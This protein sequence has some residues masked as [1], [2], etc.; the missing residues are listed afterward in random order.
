MFRLAKPLENR[1]IT[2]AQ[3]CEQNIR[4][5]A[6]RHDNAQA[7]RSAINRFTLA[8]ESD[9]GL[10]DKTYSKELAKDQQAPYVDV[11]DS[12]NHKPCPWYQL[13][14][15]FEQN[16]PVIEFELALTL[17]KAPNV[18]PKTTLISPMRATYLNDNSIQLEFT[19]HRD[20]P[21]F[22]ISI[23]EKDAFSHVINTYKQLILEML[24]C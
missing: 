23:K 9:L 13:K 7:L 14:T 3:L 11:L 12:E 20:K 21:Q 15:E 17:E 10:T 4:Y 19:A 22:I 24:K 5:Q 18:Y 8:L 1:M 2:Y 16:A 6:M